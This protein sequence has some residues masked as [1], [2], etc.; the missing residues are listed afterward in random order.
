M[1][2]GLIIFCL[3]GCTDAAAAQDADYLRGQ[4]H[5][6]HAQW[7]SWVESLS[8]DEK[9]GAS[10]ALTAAPNI[11]CDL[12][13]STDWVSGCREASEYLS[14]AI[15]QM[16]ASVDYR[17]GW[18]GRPVEPG[19]SM[20]VQ[21][22][23]QETEA[24]DRAW[25]GE[26]KFGACSRIKDRTTDLPADEEACRSHDAS[27]PLCLDY[28]GYAK[29][30]YEMKA[31]D[32]A[33]PYQYQMIRSMGESRRGDEPVIYRS[34]TYKTALV[35]L[36]NTAKGADHAKWKSSAAFADKAYGMCMSGKF[37]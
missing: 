18:F 37:Y 17:A 10:Y 8:G 35:R 22:G 13:N 36:L 11:R 12:H 7:Q 2:A 27:Q 9:I 4:G 6:D 5:D 29:I 24:S 23:G 20:V 32:P 33:Y 16:G 30:W 21:S 15:R 25:E 26:G 34:Q 14:D 28:K 31:S 1:K 19:Q 3:L